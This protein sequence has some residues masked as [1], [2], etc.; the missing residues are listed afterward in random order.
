MDQPVILCGLGRVGARVLE[1]LRTAGLPVV[2]VDNSCQP[3]D[4]RLLGARLIQ[5]DC[6]QRKT[7]EQAGVA[8]ARG[9][10]ILTS[11]DLVNVSTTLMV[12]ALDAQ[13]RIVVRV[14]NHVLM[15]RLGK[16]VAN[17]IP[18]STSALTAPVV[19]LTALTGETLGA[20]SLEDGRRQVADVHVTAGSPL[21]GQT[22]AAV[23]QGHRALV[24]AHC[25]SR[26]KQQLLLDVDPQATLA[27]GDKLVVCGEPRD[28]TGLLNQGDD[29][30]FAPRWFAWLRR[31]GRMAWATLRQVD[32]SVLICTSVLIVVVL[33]STLIY[34][35][36]IYDERHSL[37]D[38]LYRT[39]SVMATGAD[40]NEPN[41]KLG[42]WQ[43]VFVSGLR[44]FG[45][46]VVAAFTAIVT[47]FLIRAHLG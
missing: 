1:Y 32:L 13:V 40:M 30:D 44:I 41:V 7:L 19:A 34:K 26:G 22:V 24:V 46:A 25:T 27:E 3:D 28:L 31:Q 9:V 35:F 20:F 16:A 14:F 38:G 47:N 5:G 8:G 23:A 29:A 17:V 15:L 2:V 42:T 12:R 43:K 37:V 11:D 39:I 36:G 6:R 10:L 4:P 45:A 18:L 33:C 21:V